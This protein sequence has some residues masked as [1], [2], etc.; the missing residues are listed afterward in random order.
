M[1]LPVSR[2]APATKIL[3][4]IYRNAPETDVRFVFISRSSRLHCTRAPFFCFSFHHIVIIHLM[5]II[6]TILYTPLEV[7]AWVGGCVCVFLYARRDHTSFSLKAILYF[8]AI[9]TYII[10]YTNT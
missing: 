2:D 10:L 8:A 7:C 4:Y 5:T 3:L 9:M 6:Y 1:V